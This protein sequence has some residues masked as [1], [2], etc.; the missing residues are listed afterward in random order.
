[1]RLFSK[2]PV[3]SYG[4]KDD[5]EFFYSRNIFIKLKIIES[6]RDSNKLLT[7]YVVNSFERADVIAHKIYGN[8]NLFWTIYLANDILDP[9]EWLMNDI[10]LSKYIKVKYDNPYAVH[11]VER[12]GAVVDYRSAQI[13]T[14]INPFRTVDSDPE[15]DFTDYSTYNEITN[16]D[17]EE[18]LNDTKRIIRAIR[19]EYLQNFLKD[20]EAKLKGDYV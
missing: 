18:R 12:K 14:S 3:I 8:S 4:F 5:E 10:T 6:L 16:S 9:Q 20:V 19:P 15:I 13:Q 11:H 2:I 7:T 1:M 17:N